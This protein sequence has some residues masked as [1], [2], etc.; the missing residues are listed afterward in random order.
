MKWLYL[1]AF[2]LALSVAAQQGPLPPGA[3]S[4]DD[5]PIAATTPAALSPELSA[6]EDKIEARDYDAARPLLLTRLASHPDDA[7]ALFDLGFVEDLQ[8]QQDA[9]ERDYAKAI[10]VD[11]KQFE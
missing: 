4:P 3:H 8:G 7:R 6:A 5:P 10:A 9:A 1:S 2:T 11:P